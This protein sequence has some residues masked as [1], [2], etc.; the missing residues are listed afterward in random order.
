MIRKVFAHLL[1][2]PDE[3][4]INT[5]DVTEETESFDDLLEFE[6]GDWVIIDI[7]E[8]QALAPPEVDPLENLLIEHPSMS[9]Y[10]LRCQRN[11]DDLGSEEEEEEEEDS[12]VPVP[13][14][15]PIPWRMTA[16]GSIL[17]CDSHFHALQTARAHTEHRK[18]SR[19]AL[20]RQ[21][22]VKTRFYPAGKR[23]GY[24]KQ[25][26]QRLYNY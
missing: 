5:C 17:V 4:D 20:C 1:G 22:L 7:H 19:S 18:L 25:P 13:V 9:V 23:Y 15:R 8:G 2:T 24:F 26:C 14:R 16:W 21:N 6:E 11:E 3:D 10:K 12:A